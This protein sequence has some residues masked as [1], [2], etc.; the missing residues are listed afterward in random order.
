MTEQID[1]YQRRAKEYEQVYLKVER[2]SDLILIKSY[3][4][5]QFIDK[6]IIEIACGTGYWTELLAGQAKSIQASDVNSKVID[7]AK[8]KAYPRRNV[9]FEI[10]DFN[11]L[12]FTEE[13]AEG[14]FG[15]FIWSHILLQELKSFLSLALRQV[16][17]GADLVFIDNKY[18]LGSSSEISRTDQNGNTYQNRQ[19]ESGESFEVIKNFPTEGEVKSLIETCAT[20]FEWTDFEHYWIVKFRKR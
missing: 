7:I 17:P 14:L 5:E 10:K 19:L 16:K 15:G 3:L 20:D 8:Q 1:Y 6:E 18:V 13:P 11:Y 4:K 2:Q 12:S 9:S